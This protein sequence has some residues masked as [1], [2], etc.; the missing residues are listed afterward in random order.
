MYAL[1][2]LLAMSLTGLTWSFDWYRNAFLCRLWS[3][4]YSEKFRRTENVERRRGEAGGAS[5]IRTIEGNR[6]NDRK[7]SGFGCWQRIHD[8]LKAQNPDVVEITVGDG[9]ASVVSAG[10]L[11]NVGLPTATVLT[12]ILAISPPV[13][14]YS[15]AAPADRLRGWIY[16]VHTGGF[17]G[18]PARILWLLICLVRSKPAAYG[19][20]YLD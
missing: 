3:G 5:H 6:G 12:V 13:M 15:A 19:L 20:L 1:V 14:E 4:I 9:T 18:V 2:V 7:P 8:E 16:S 17:G 11:G 10:K